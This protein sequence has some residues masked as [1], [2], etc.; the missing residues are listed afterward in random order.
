MTAP[1]LTITEAEMGAMRSVAETISYARTKE[2]HKALYHNFYHFV[3]NI[4]AIKQIV[5]PK[6]FLITYIHKVFN[7]SYDDQS[8]EYII[9]YEDLVNVED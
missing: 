1:R 9:Y 6:K 2:K 5:L 7:V 3:K 8:V 4:A